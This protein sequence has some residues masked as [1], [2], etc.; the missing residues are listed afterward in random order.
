[1]AIIN[2]SLFSDVLLDTVDNDVV[3][4]F[5]GDDYVYGGFGNDSINGGT[6]IDTM[7][8]SF[9]N[10][11]ITLGAVG[12]VDKGF[13]GIDSIFAVEN[14]VGNANFINTIDA[15]TGD[16][17]VVSLAVDLSLNSLIVNDVPG[18]G[19]LSFGVFNFNDVTG[20]SQ[21][22]NIS[23]D[24]QANVLD[25][26]EGNDILFGDG[27]DDLLL[28]WTGNDVLDGWTGNDI[29]NGEAGD[30]TL[31]GY[32]GNDTLNGG[33]GIDTA[34]YS[35][36]NQGITLGPGGLISKGLAGVD[37]IFAVENIVGN[38]DFINT[39]DA[40][41]GDS[42]L[43][44]L[45]VDLSL[46]SLTVNN[47]PGLGSLNFGVFNFIDVTGSTEADDIAGNLQANILD[48]DGGNDFLFGDGGNDL[49]LGGTGSDILDGWT[50]SDTLDG[51]SGNDTLLGYTGN[52]VL[53]GGTGSD[54]LMGESGDDFLNGYGGTVGEFDVLSGGSGADTFALGDAVEL[55]YQG[56]GY[57]TITDFNFFEGDKIQVI[58]SSNNYSLSFQDFSGSFDLDTLIFFGSDLIGVVQDN[59]NVV[60]AFDF[61]SA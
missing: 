50:G 36:L 46:N 6:G 16:S 49:L 47:V 12:V 32:L 23:G 40:S 10:N 2:G 11:G 27:G 60:P 59:T 4:A 5:G 21:A 42:G 22:D 43:V 7:D 17:S 54:M 13:A 31:M 48:G 44:S 34:D 37:S 26:W 9:L 8:Y 28:G 1:M 30:D 61:V 38:A 33:S 51:G 19:T 35:N 45:N 55:F 58:G 24:H 14:I 3:T 41:S 56:T 29:L 52:D 15:S 57:A 39:I 18:L 25:G 53:F 20:T